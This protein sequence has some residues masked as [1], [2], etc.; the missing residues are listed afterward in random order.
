MSGLAKIISGGQTGVDRGALDAALERGFA[1]GGSCPAGRRAEDGMIPG[2]YPLTE[3]ADRSYTAR[4]LR[5]VD[6]S[7]GTLILHFGAVTGGTALTLR[8][9]IESGK[10]RLLIDADAT[11]AE[12]AAAHAAEFCEAR[13][14]AVLNVAGPRASSAPGARDYAA[15]VVGG[16]LDLQREGR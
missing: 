10:P 9:C 5:N 7:D 13:S 14:I 4:T 6:E 12:D 1:C 8:R 16:L 3:L 11:P 15:A 2:R